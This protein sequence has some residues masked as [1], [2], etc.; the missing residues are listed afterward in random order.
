MEANKLVSI[1]LLSLVILVS[2]ELKD[3]N[4]LTAPA[5]IPVE[6]GNINQTRLLA[7]QRFFYYP[8]PGV[9]A[10]G[11]GSMSTSNVILGMRLIRLNGTD[12][13]HTLISGGVNHKFVNFDFMGV[14]I[15]RAY[16]F[17]I[18]LFGSAAT[19]NFSTVLTLLSSF[20]IYIFNF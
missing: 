6:W 16:D 19:K 2:G 12:G 17:D 13:L 8:T 3:G 20:L 9:F 14:G 18:E 15:G 11:N 10:T 4:D 1:F 5:S 7:Q